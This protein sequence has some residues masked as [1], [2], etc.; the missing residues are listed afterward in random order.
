MGLALDEP[1]NDDE[2]FEIKGFKFV[3]E[4]TLINEVGPMI[5]DMGPYGFEVRSNLAAG[6]CGGSCSSC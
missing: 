2:V 4:K 5:L 6:S 3:V 1:K